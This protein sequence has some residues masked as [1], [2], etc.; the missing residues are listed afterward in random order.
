MQ[1]DVE[2]V[3]VHAVTESLEPARPFGSAAR[4]IA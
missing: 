1:K 4:A 3:K 2:F